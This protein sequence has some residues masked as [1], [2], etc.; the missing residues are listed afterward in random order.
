MCRSDRLPGGERRGS[1]PAV[2]LGLV[3]LD[4]GCGRRSE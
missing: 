1:E 4:I 2:A 3:V